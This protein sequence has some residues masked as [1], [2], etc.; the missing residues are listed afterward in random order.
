MHT[1]NLS[2]SQVAV[3]S[4]EKDL[5]V[6]GSSSLSWN[7]H[8]DLVISKVNKLFGIIYRTCTIDCDQ[9]TMLVLYKSLVRPQLEYASQVWSPYTKEKIK[10]I[11]RVQRRAPKFILKYDLTYPERLAKLDLLRLQFGREV[12]DLCF[13]FKCLNCKGHIDFD[14]LSYVSFKSYKYDMRNS[15]AILAKGRFR[16]DVFKFSFFNPIVNLWNGLPVAIRTIDR[17]S[18]FRKQ[19]IMSQFYIS[20]INL[21]KDKFI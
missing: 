11:E 15:E 2:G 6:H 16:T 10:V 19:V 13:F 8:I 9:K 7:D 1:Y 5:G 17:V 4:I 3:V 18:L 12:L 21:S 14:V 20:Q